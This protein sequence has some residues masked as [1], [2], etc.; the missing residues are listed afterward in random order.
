MFL[1]FE[2]RAVRRVGRHEK[3]EVTAGRR[4]QNSR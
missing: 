2:N 3:E 4:K 1:V